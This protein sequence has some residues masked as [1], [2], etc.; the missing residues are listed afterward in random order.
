MYLE[1]TLSPFSRT[2][3]LRLFPGEYTEG[4]HPGTK[5]SVTGNLADLHF[6][7]V[8][9]LGER[10]M[11]LGA[12]FTSGALLYLFYDTTAFFVQFLQCHV[13]GS[14]EDNVLGTPNIRCCQLIYQGFGAFF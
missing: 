6:S 11:M 12:M 10:S 4:G 5:F 14:V 9:G 2:D 1:Q 3:Q 7:C 13:L 8:A